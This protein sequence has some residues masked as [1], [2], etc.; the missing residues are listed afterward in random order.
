[1][2]QS[3]LLEF[4]SDAFSIEPDEDRETNPGIVG[5]ALARW[6]A[7]GLRDAG[8]AVGEIVAEDF[9]WCVPVRCDPYKSYVACAGEVEAP[10]AWRVFAFVEGGLLRRWLGRERR[11]EALGRVYCAVKQ[12]LE[13]A[14]QIRELRESG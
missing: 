1:M 7:D 11:D 13:N 9:A 14:P 10:H 3:P 6:L 5:R 8:L 4:R 12:V 2:S